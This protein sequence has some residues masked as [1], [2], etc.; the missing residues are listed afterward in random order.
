[1]PRLLAWGLR[2][3]EKNTR[4]GEWMALPKR[5][6]LLTIFGSVLLLGGIVLYFYPNAE[7]KR[8]LEACKQLRLEVTEQEVYEVMGPH[9][10]SS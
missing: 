5:W 3:P 1:M 9:F 8:L 4:R 2:L 10:F 7:Y 6:M